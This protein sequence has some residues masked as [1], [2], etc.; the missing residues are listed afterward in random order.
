MGDHTG[1]AVNAD[2]QPLVSIVTPVYHE[3]K[4]LA[5]CIE[6]VLAQ[7]YVNWDYTIVNNC[8]TDRSLE[9]ALHY[10]DQDSRIRIHNNAQFVGVVA[11]H[12]VAFRQ[13]SPRSKYCKLVEADDWIFPECISSMVEVAEAN[14]SVGMV[15]AYALQ[16]NRVMWDGLPYPSTVVSGENICRSRLL[17]DLRV[18]GSP[19]SNLLRSDLIRKHEDFYTPSNLHGDNDAYFKVLQESDFGFVYQVLTFIRR[20]NGS[21]T[22]FCERIN[23]YVGGALEEVIRYGPHFLNEREYGIQARTRL[24]EYYKFLADNAFEGQPP[25][26]WSY[27]KN[28]LRELGCPFNRARF[29]RAVLRRACDMLFNPKRT[30]EGLIRHWSRTRR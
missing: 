1:N 14:P 13:I 3:E 9:I 22:S 7:T 2:T 8:S 5:Q 18:F 26:F 11:N 21:T 6:S 4:F 10:A 25:E 28:K 15:G 16:R 17:G 19:S 29:A 27:H 23:T 12:N 24:A 30:A 20:D